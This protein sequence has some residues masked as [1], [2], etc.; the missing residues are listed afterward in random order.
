MNRFLLRSSRGTSLLGGIILAGMLGAAAVGQWGVAKQSQVAQTAQ[1]GPGAES[2][3]T[4]IQDHRGTQKYYPLSSS[5]NLEM[6]CYPGAV[7]KISK[8]TFQACVNQNATDPS[9]MTKCIERGNPTIKLQCSHYQR[10]K[11]VFLI[12]SV[13]L[14]DSQA[15]KQCTYVE[16]NARGMGISYSFKIS[17]QASDYQGGKYTAFPDKCS[18]P[19][20][21]QAKTYC[22]T[23]NVNFPA[24]SVQC[25]TEG[26][27]FCNIPEKVTNKCALLIFDDNTRNPLCE[28]TGVPDVGA[29]GNFNGKAKDGSSTDIPVAGKTCADIMGSAI[30]VLS[31]VVPATPAAAS[32][33]VAAGVTQ[34]ACTYADPEA[35]TTDLCRSLVVPEGYNAEVYSADPTSQGGNK[36]A[37]TM[38]A[39]CKKGIDTNSAKNVCMYESSVEVQEKLDKL[40]GNDRSVLKCDAYGNG[41]DC[42]SATGQAQGG[43]KATASAAATPTPGASPGAP[44]AAP[45]VKPAPDVVELSPPD[46]SLITPANPCPRVL[47]KDGVRV[48]RPEYSLLDKC[49]IIG[50][51]G[52]TDYQT[53]SSSFCASRGGTLHGNVCV[54]PSESSGSGLFGSSGSSG[55]FM[56]NFLKGAG[57]YAIGS[58]LSGL[59]TG[60]NSNT[61]SVSSSGTSCG[62]PPTQPDASY[63]TGGTW[64]VTYSGSCVSGWQCVPSAT[65]STTPVATLECAST[66]AA[67]GAKVALNYSCTSGTPTGTNFDVGSASPATVTIPSLPDGA[68]SGS[69]SYGLACTKGDLVGRAT[70]SIQVTRPTPV[71]TL[72]CSPSIADIGAPLTLAYACS[73][74]T[75]VGGG[76]SATTSSPVVVAA[77][78]PPSGTNTATYGL[79]CTDAGLVGM[80]SCSVQLAKTSLV[81]V[82]NP[83]IVA[84]GDS[85]TLGWVTAGMSACVVS[86]PELP[87][88]T[89][90]SATSTS[91]NGSLV[92]PSLT[93]TTHFAI[94]CATLGGNTKSATTTV[95]VQ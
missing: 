47:N 77:P 71:A 3:M 94:N 69:F 91:V 75:A 36:D 14:L 29:N 88:F 35:N 32:P 33:S 66:T 30:G 20:F 7:T 31:A 48:V 11:N 84:S 17:K 37:T 13:T 90:S 25:F 43:G 12:D 68:T 74:G 49:A 41:A 21:L 38:V 22:S 57:I 83:S 54:I 93:G 42:D 95:T 79:T 39:V 46:G 16:S 76:F 26:G 62:T 56:D 19:P 81:F 18:G 72:S 59:F 24:L 51:P 52:T 63:C 34:D 28:R 10:G 86:S 4:G 85:A 87:G 50:A 82:A 53:T 58:A 5:S 61:G 65:T 45:A 40:A 70:C 8:S 80:A 55:S 9:A 89:S 78:T 23:R 2:S 27:D 92:T 67:V 1:A 64:R 6:N 44:G 60:S 73:S 15:P